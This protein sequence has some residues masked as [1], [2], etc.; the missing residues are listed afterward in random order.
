M[1]KKTVQINEEKNEYK[2][3]EKRKK[4]DSYLNTLFSYVCTTTDNYESIN[5]NYVSIN[6]YMIL[7]SGKKIKR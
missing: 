6:D 1:L 4:E 3:I 2:F 5:D 7:K